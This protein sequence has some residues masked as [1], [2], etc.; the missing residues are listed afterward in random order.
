MRSKIK[1][2]LSSSIAEQHVTAIK[3]AHELHDKEQK[4]YKKTK[5][6]KQNRFELSLDY[7]FYDF[8]ILWEFLHRFHNELNIKI[9]QGYLDSTLELLWLA[10]RFLE[11]GHYD[12]AWWYLRKA[13]ESWIYCLYT[14]TSTENKKDKLIWIMRQRK[15][16]DTSLSLD[17]NEVYKI[18][19]YLSDYYIH[20][21][22]ISS[23]I[24]F[25]SNKYSQIYWTMVVLVIVM[26]YLAVDMIPEKILVEYRQ[27]NIINPIDD[28][29]FYAA[30]I[31]PL[32]WSGVISSSKTW[33]LNGLKYSWI[34]SHQFKDK[35]IG[36]D[37]NKRIRI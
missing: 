7:L 2:L 34:Q 26:S 15:S 24:S 33:F 30:Y 27:K 5:Q 6:F 8:Q 12:V 28:Y 20:K 14:G 4:V 22:D 37:L 10:N 9:E 31:W 3:I 17:E 11:I 19:S 25:N 29:K 36:L 13:F 32:V 35:T 23:D 1:S 18:Y 16:N 21:T